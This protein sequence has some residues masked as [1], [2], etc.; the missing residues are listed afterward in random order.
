MDSSSSQP[1]KKIL[2]L[3][4]LVLALVIVFLL[5]R[6]SADWGGTK[7]AAPTADPTA[8]ASATAQPTGKPGAKG[9][10]EF[11]PSHT[12]PKA[13]ELLRSAPLREDGDPRALGKVDAPVVMVAYEDFSCPMCTRYFTDVH[14]KLKPMVEDGTLRIEFRDVVIFPNYGSDIAA[15]GSR[16]AAAQG[17]FWEFT[18]AAYAAA[19]A[20]AHPTYTED[21]VVEIAKTAGVPDLEKFRTDLQSQELADAVTDETTHAHQNMGINGTPF[22]VINDAAVP[23][24]LP[25]DFMV[26]TIENQLQEAKQK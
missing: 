11:A 8:A 10:Q 15:V 6:A 16:A 23:G 1:L 4:A 5:G 14:P 18:E 25:V 9:E 13:L 19:G 3:C 20:G 22:F 12:N 21:S 17:K 26:K 7:N 24:S 2:M